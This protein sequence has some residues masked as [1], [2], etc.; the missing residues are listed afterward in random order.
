MNGRSGTGGLAR[1]TGPRPAE[2][3]LEPELGVG[4]QSRSTSQV[5]DWWGITVD[6]DR[7][8]SRTLFRALQCWIARAACIWGDTSRVCSFAGRHLVSTM[9]PWVVLARGPASSDGFA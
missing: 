8:P 9:G 6:I 7:G 3:M 2:H 5:P 4:C 1:R